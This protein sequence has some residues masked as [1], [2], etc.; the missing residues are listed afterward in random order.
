MKWRRTSG[1]PSGPPFSSNSCD[2]FLQNLGMGASQMEELSAIN[3]EPYAE[4]KPP[5]L[6]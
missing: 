4:K 5:A 3:P 1:D 2:E 6:E